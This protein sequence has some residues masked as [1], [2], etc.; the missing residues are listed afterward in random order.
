LSIVCFIL[1]YKSLLHKACEGTAFLECSSR[2]ILQAKP[3][4]S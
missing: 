2:F 4:K 3:A 1:V